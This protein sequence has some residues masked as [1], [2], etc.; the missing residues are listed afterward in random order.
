[1]KATT[2]KIT[3]TKN[4]KEQKKKSK[5]SFTLLKTAEWMN[6]ITS[7]DVQSYPLY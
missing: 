5:S 3:I 6:E 4:K 7:E 2:A 1:M